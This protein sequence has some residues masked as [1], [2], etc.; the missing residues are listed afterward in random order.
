M[1]AWVR[2]VGVTLTTRN[3]DMTRKSGTIFPRNPTD[4]MRSGTSGRS[5]ARVAAATAMEIADDK[6]TGEEIRT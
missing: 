5:R 4:A 1:P 3:L 6:A 2:I